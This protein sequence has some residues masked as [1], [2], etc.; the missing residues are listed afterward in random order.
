METSNENKIL[1]S[2]FVPAYYPITLQS[3]DQNISLVSSMEEEERTYKARLL[4]SATNAIEAK[5]KIEK[6][7]AIVNKEGFFD[8]LIDDVSELV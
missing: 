8:V 5:A 1:D 4:I 7:R 2:T 6:I 3:W